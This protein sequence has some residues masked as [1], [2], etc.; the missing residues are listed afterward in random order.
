MAGKRPLCLKGVLPRGP[1]C[2]SLGTR[3]QLRGGG[4]RCWKWAPAPRQ[5]WLSCGSWSVAS[6]EVWRVKQ[7]TG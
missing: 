4:R 7:G 3:P 5:P 6:P 2:L 1:R